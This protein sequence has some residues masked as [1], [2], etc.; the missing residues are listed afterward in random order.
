M[1][2]ESPDSKAVVFS[3]WTSMLD[4]IEPKLLSLG[5]DFVR[6]DGSLSLSQRQNVLESFNQKKNVKV[7]LM[8][9]KAGGVGLNLVAANYLFFL[10][11]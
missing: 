6:F 10:G 1:T 11:M 3:Q 2:K 8:S 5:L 4:L 9:L 7:I